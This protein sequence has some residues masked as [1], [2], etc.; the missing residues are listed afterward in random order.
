[1]TE[2]Y[3]KILCWWSTRKH[4]D[5]L[6][7]PKNKYVI[8]IYCSTLTETFH[9]NLPLNLFATNKY[10]YIQYY[11]TSC[12]QM[13]TWK[14]YLHQFSLYGLFFLGSVG[15]LC[16]HFLHTSNKRRVYMVSTSKYI[17]FNK[18]YFTNKMIEEHKLI[19]MA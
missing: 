14:Q 7:G 19:K 16:Y 13:Y 11:H 17:T 6:Y 2:H 15:I 18:F 3:L 4:D 12:H 1:M 8:L 10:V 5:D 9:K